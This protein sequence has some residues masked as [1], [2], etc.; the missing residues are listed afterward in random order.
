MLRE[1]IWKSAVN[2]NDE[3]ETQNLQRA[4]RELERAWVPTGGRV[5]LIDLGYVHRKQLYIPKTAA[6]E[7]E[8]KLTDANQEQPQ[9]FFL[10]P[11][12]SSQLCVTSM[13]LGPGKV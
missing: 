2:V 1:A 10:S 11:N 9:P 13:S 5:D 4:V 7:A 8:S 3:D 6:A 12:H